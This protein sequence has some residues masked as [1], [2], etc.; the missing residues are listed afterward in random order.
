MKQPNYF[1]FL[2]KYNIIRNTSKF[3]NSPI[4]WNFFFN[5]I[6]NLDGQVQS[7][8]ITILYS[9]YFKHYAHFKI[10][11]TSR[12]VISEYD[13]GVPQVFF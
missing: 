6:Y 4:L 9:K 10:N 5:P 3:V 2:D 12:T 1:S 13:G 8:N 7:D 11:A